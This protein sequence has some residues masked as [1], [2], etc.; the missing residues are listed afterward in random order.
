MSCGGYWNCLTI[1]AKS[2][3]CDLVTLGCVLNG[4]V[5]VPHLADAEED[6]CSAVFKDGDVGTGWRSRVIFET[7]GA[8]DLS[9]LS[10]G[11]C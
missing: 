9:C 8:F 11:K 5:E 2:L 10:I 3:A 7:Q 1:H 4:H 6:R